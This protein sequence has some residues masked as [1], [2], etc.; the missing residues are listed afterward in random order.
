MIL[1]AYIIVTVVFFMAHSSPIN[2]VR[3]LLQQH[4]T[5]QNTKALSALFGLNQPLW[6]QYLNYM[7]GLLHGNLGYSME[8]NTLGQPVWGILQTG[9]PQTLKL[10]VYALIL[11]LLIGLPIGLISALRQNSI[12]DHTGQSFMIL[13]Y[14]IPA[15]VFCPLAQLLFGSILHWLPVTGWGDTGWSF[16]GWIPNGGSGVQTSLKEMILPVLIYTAGLAGFFAKS[17]RSFLLE[18]LQ[19]DY[20]RTAKAKGLKNRVVIYRHAVKNTLLPLA[21]IVGPTIAYL[22]VGAFIIEYFFGIPGIA[23]I[24]AT[25]VI[26]SDF[27]VI[28]A[29]TLILALFVVFINMLTDIFYAVVDPRVRL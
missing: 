14:V 13:L 9:A 7:G 22:I 17:F 26:N 20:I 15:F 11:S 18:V 19:Q 21:S 5:Y 8:Q 23:D 1:I 16:F 24:T 25:S 12:I 27:A 10:G 28:E 2:P 29:T 3:V 4:A 6:R